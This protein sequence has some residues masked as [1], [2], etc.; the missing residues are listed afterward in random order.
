MAMKNNGMERMG[1]RTMPKVRKHGRTRP[2]TL[3]DLVAAAMEVAGGDA[4]EAS[5]LLSSR[6]MARALGRRIVVG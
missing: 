3:G 6:E 4:K 1:R 5:A 2:V